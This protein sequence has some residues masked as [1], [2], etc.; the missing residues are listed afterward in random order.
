MTDPNRMRQTQAMHW[1]AA[2]SWLLFVTTMNAQK[3]TALGA[4]LAAEV[5]SRSE[6]VES[7][8]IQS[9]VD[10]IGGELAGH[11]SAQDY[12]WRFRLI[13]HYWDRTLSGPLALPGGYVFVP[14]ELIARAK[15]GDEF[16]GFLA[17]SMSQLVVQRGNHI[18][19][20]GVHPP[21]VP[22]MATAG[23]VLTHGFEAVQE[24]ASRLVRPSLKAVNRQ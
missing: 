23:F 19:F 12:P 1:R 9:F 17:Q 20:I 14:V 24:E 10:R 6:V 22:A 18:F 3:E 15:S 4:R 2:V 21:P 13:R 7:T 16:A 8:L 5:A 11:L